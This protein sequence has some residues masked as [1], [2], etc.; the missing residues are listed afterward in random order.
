MSKIENFDDYDVVFVGYPIWWGDMP[1]IMYTFLES[2]DW[3]GKGVIPFNTH[4]GSIQAQTSCF[5]TERMQYCIRYER[6]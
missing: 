3:T 4:E 6:L 5:H 2:Y 1:V